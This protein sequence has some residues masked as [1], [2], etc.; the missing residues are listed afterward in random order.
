MIKAKRGDNVC[1]GLETESTLRRWS[2]DDEID[3]LSRGG[4]RQEIKEHI[5]A[6]GGAVGQNN[7]G[8]S[9]SGR[10]ESSQGEGR[11]H[12]QPGED[13]GKK[14]KRRQRPRSRR[15]ASMQ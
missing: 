7:R 2:E 8:K 14:T 9:R 12:R 15:L 5:R 13:K 10:R 11:T 1:V 4:R 3:S 6:L